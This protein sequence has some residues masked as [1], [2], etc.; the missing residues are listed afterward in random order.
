MNKSKVCQCPICMIGDVY[1]F[2]NPRE[3]EPYWEFF[4]VKIQ[5]DRCGHEI[6]KDFVRIELREGNCLKWKDYH[7]DCFNYE[8]STDIR[9]LK[10][11]Q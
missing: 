6:Q 5:C 1:S 2:R 4:S 11:K 3:T 7:V 9:K 10:E 8:F